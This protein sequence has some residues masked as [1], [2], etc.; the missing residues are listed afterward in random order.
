MG[1]NWLN[2]EG[3]NRVHTWSL[4]KLRSIHLIGVADQ[5]GVLPP[6]DK[7]SSL[8]TPS[9]EKEGMTEDQKIR[10]CLLGPPKGRQQGEWADDGKGKLLS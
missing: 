2:R 6:L 8:M 10:A 9:D 4:Q 7:T 3:K 5:R 1:A